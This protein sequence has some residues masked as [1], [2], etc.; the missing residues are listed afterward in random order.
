MYAD[1]MQHLYSAPGSNHGG[2][3]K[4]H[5]SLAHSPKHMNSSGT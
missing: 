3:T 4:I 5:S 2:E 1:Y